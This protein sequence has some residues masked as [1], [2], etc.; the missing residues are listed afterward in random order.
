MKLIQ[1][2]GKPPTPFSVFATPAKAA[3][4]ALSSCCWNKGLI[5]M[6]MVCE[7][8]SLCRRGGWWGQERGWERRGAGRGAGRALP[9]PPARQRPWLPGERNCGGR[10]AK[11]GPA[12]RASSAKICHQEEK[13]FWGRIW[14]AWI[15][16]VVVVERRCTRNTV[17]TPSKYR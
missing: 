4:P 16:A 5:S 14:S 15:E 8:A 2:T 1:T 7:Q 10:A 3:K 9:A 13:Q 12:R 11:G 6:F 17:L